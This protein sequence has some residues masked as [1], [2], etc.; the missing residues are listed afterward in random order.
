ML[1]HKSWRVR[2][3][4]HND[5]G[6]DDHYDGSGGGDGELCDICN[7]R[8]SRCTTAEC[9]HRGTL[10]ELSAGGHCSTI[11]ATPVH[12][13]V[14]RCAV[15]PNARTMQ[16][17]VCII[18]MLDEHG[19]AWCENGGGEHEHMASHRRAWPSMVRALMARA[20]REPWCSDGIPCE[21]GTG[22]LPLQ[23][24]T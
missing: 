2:E 24:G 14:T 7:V 1:R 21:P 4:V 16:A 22:G 12:S 17:L 6:G 8:S 13:D 3:Q 9:C 23:H 11:H 19:P 5:G 10:V 15:R 20:H 18:R